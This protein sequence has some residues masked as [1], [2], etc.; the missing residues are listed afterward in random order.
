MVD[1]IGVTLRC[2]AQ[3]FSNI[4]LCTEDMKS[5]YRQIPL[6]R[7]DVR[8]AIT[9][10]FCPDSKEV[11]LREMFGRSFRAHLLTSRCSQRY[12]HTFSDHFFD[13]FFCMEPIATVESA[14][15]C[16]RCMFEELGFKLD[17][18]KTQPPSPVCAILG[19]HFSTEALAMEQAIRL[20]PKPSRLSHP[21]RSAWLRTSSRLP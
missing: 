15:F 1:Y 10:V 11:F 16:L 4:Y 17:P 9:A 6:A 8:F 20:E 14:I 18:S 2:L 5:A 21:L 19:F 7:E 13:D 3:F 12:F